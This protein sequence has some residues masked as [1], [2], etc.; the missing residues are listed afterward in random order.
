MTETEAAHGGDE[1]GV[2]RS[3]WIQA[4]KYILRLEKMLAQ[5]LPIQLLFSPRW[6][7][8]AEN[9]DDT[10]I[11]QDYRRWLDQR[12]MYL[13]LVNTVALVYCAHLIFANLR[14][15]PA[16]WLQQLITIL[17]AAATLTFGYF[18]NRYQMYGLAKLREQVAAGLDR[19]N[20]LSIIAA[21][22]ER[23]LSIY[24]YLP[25]W[26]RPLISKPRRL[27]EALRLVFHNLTWYLGR[28]RP[29]INVAY[30]IT[31]QFFCFVAAVLA[32]T[33]AVLLG[34]MRRLDLIGF[35]LLVSGLIILSF[36]DVQRFRHRVF[37]EETL[38]Y[39]ARIK[40]AGAR[41]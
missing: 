19:E 10:T 6:Q 22:D 23:L 11:D 15:D 24:D 20:V 12:I 35:T 2:D 30:V 17:V 9:P 28:P 39:I 4:P 27:E 36:V 26:L 29:V 40:L 38:R 14:S 34:F 13:Y 33:I 5:H 21:H 32:I 37:R 8:A 3:L 31:S 16:L 1:P 18:L 7:Q 25:G 41:D